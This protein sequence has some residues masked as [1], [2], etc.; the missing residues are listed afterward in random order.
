MIAITGLIAGEHAQERRVEA[1]GGVIIGRRGEFVIE[2]E[3]IEK[4]AQP[5]IVMRAEARMRAERIGHLRQRLAEMGGDKL[6][7]RNIVGDLA[8]SVHV[9]GKG[10]EARLHLIPGQD[11][12]GVPHH[13]GARDFAESADMR[14]AGGAIAGLE[15]HFG[16]AGALDA[17]GRFSVLLRRA[18]HWS[19][20]AASKSESGEL[21]GLAAEGMIN[22]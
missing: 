17:F 13:A 19:V 3:G 11:T 10:D 8:Q 1:A 9:V 5:R 14:Q 18:R 6:L 7:V 4:G 12:E 20:R 16:L 21:S 22:S 2:A 15:Q